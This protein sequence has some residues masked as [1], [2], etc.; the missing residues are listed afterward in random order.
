MTSTEQVVIMLTD[1]Q[2]LEEIE[3]TAPEV[4]CPSYRAAAS[5]LCGCRGTAGEYLQRL[6]GEATRREDESS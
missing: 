6:L 1:A 5:V 3:A 4:C 2:L